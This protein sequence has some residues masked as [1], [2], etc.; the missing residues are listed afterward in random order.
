MPGVV[1]GEKAAP[2]HLLLRLEPSPCAAFSSF[3]R[4]AIARAGLPSC[5][6]PSCRPPVCR[7]PV[8]RPPS[9]RPPVCRPPV[10][11]PP[12]CRATRARLPWRADDEL[13]PR[14][15]PRRGLPPMPAMRIL[16]A[17][18]T[19][20]VAMPAQE[21]RSP[22]TFH[23]G[24][25]S[26][27]VR[28]VHQ[29]PSAG[30]GRTVLAADLPRREEACAQPAGGD[31]GS[32][33]AAV[34]S[35][36]RPRRVP[37]RTASVRRR[38]RQVPPLGRGGNAGGTGRPPAAAARVSGRLAARRTRPDPED[39]RGPTRCRP[40]AATSTATSRCSSTCPRTSG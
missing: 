9:C 27:R 39:V 14:L 28:L 32:H 7:P 38:H 20:A 8:C 3:V 36:G 37:Q 26:A 18:V 17:V 31:G 35:G 33:H 12:V 40:A 6:P 24:H 19:L 21:D 29:V 16:S 13:V 23:G 5:R 2:E 34:A 15:S 1:T 11:R 22:P 4:G 25:R 10:C 30:G